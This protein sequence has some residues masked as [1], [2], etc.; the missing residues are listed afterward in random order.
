MVFKEVNNCVGTK[1]IFPAIETVLLNF[2]V[3]YFKLE[4]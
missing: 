2:I 1:N 4:F 3:T